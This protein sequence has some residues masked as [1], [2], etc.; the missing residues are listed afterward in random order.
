ME[1]IWNAHNQS[2]SPIDRNTSAGILFPDSCILVIVLLWSRAASRARPPI[3]PI[4]FQRMSNKNESNCIQDLIRYEFPAT[5]MSHPYEILK[6]SQLFATFIAMKLLQCQYR[7]RYREKITAFPRQNSKIY[8][9]FWSK[10]AGI[11][12]YINKKL[13][14]TNKHTNPGNEVTH[15]V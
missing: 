5:K 8:C 15:S 10:R 4:L 9:T 1:F 3:N 14:Q 7:Y 11:C 2:V 6:L 12:T 13:K